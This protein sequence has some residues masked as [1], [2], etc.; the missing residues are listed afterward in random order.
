[1]QFHVRQLS[2]KVITKFWNSKRKL[3]FY[4]E[5]L[6]DNMQERKILKTEVWTV[7]LCA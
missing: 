1:M 6:Y 5:K 7:H 3:M 4:L 2:S